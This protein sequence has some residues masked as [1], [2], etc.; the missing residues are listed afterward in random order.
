MNA[1]Y[2][3]GSEITTIE[4]NAFDELAS[5]KTLN[6]SGNE[7]SS[8]NTTV[9]NLAVS[10]LQRLSLAGNQI[11]SIAGNSFQHLTSLE[12][13][14]LS[15]QRSGGLILD[16]EDLRGLVR[17]NELLLS[18]AEIEDIHED[19]FYDL[20]NCELLDLSYNKLDDNI[21]TEFKHLRSLHTLDL[22]H[23]LFVS[24]SNI[25]A[26]LR[27]GNL[28]T[29]KLVGGFVDS[30]DAHLTENFLSQLNKLEELDLSENYFMSISDNAFQDLELLR[31][32]YMQNVTG[33]ESVRG[34]LFQHTHSLQRLHLEN[35]GF[36][37]VEGKPFEGG[38]EQLFEIRWSGGEL[39][40][41]EDESF[42]GLDGLRLLDLDGNRI[43]VSSLHGGAKF[44][45]LKQLETI[46]LNDQRSCGNGCELRSDSFRGRTN[47]MEIEL[48]NSN[49]NSFDKRAFRQEGN[50]ERL[51]LS[52]NLL[53]RLVFESF[54]GVKSL[55]HLDL[56]FNMIEEIDTLAFPESIE[57]KTLDLSHNRF[58]E[59]RVQWIRNAKALRELDI[60]NNNMERFLNTESGTTFEDLRKLVLNDNDLGEMKVSSFQGFP[61]LQELKLDRGGVVMF[62][63]NT[64]SPLKML[65]SMS[66]EGANAMK[67]DSLNFLYL[68]DWDGLLSMVPEL[69]LDANWGL[70]RDDCED[71]MTRPSPIPQMD[72]AMFCVRELPTTTPTATPSNTP[73][74]SRSPSITPT[75]SESASNTPT[76]SV[77]AT[78]SPTPSVSASVSST[79]SITASPS[80]TATPTRTPSYSSSSTWT[81]TP[82][83]TPPVDDADAAAA[84]A[85]DDDGLS[86]GEI[87]VV[88]I[89]VLVV[90][91]I[92]AISAIYYFRKRKSPVTRSQNEGLG[93]V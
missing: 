93:E 40:S 1:L 91:A 89:I 33:I 75:P 20:G 54:R 8:I 88:V 13:L 26:G 81:A 19:A 42:T 51:D 55:Q 47:L 84:A 9:F 27:E 82:T 66:I 79:P 24:P 59:F 10:G 36:T 52:H 60:S 4:E 76:P 5:L 41:M 22:S 78:N 28:A 45:G 80:L 21:S 2:F 70:N 63:E 38:P 74:S 39:S 6:L 68:H 86:E 31:D 62:E 53:E 49:I 30:G 43:E 57:L 44:S 23:N 69:N 71:G 85:D 7:I 77:S 50:L 56:S 61:N 32:L 34:S 15:A 16:D 87:A 48:S 46:K 18:N 65:M 92:V 90:I 25:L 83:T 58:T 67:N 64:F 12:H 17:V 72:D 3:D 14:D 73:S 11:S 35:S 29:L 37:S